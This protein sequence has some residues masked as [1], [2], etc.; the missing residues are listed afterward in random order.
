MLHVAT[1]D[2]GQTPN[3]MLEMCMKEFLTRTVIHVCNCQ[4]LSEINNRTYM[5]ATANAKSI[6]FLA[7]DSYMAI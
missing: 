5:S 2:K 7:D 1:R 6:T 4:V 3:Q